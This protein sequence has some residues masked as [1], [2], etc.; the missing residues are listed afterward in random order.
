MIALVAKDSRECD[1]GASVRPSLVSFRVVLSC[2]VDD[3]SLG[4]PLRRRNKLYM[5]LYYER[6]S[7][8][9]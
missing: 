4:N 5:F 2:H 7:A 1:L 9:D 3:S 8:F 6:W